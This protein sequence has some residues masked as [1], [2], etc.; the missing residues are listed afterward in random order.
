MKIGDMVICEAHPVACKIGAI[1]PL[2]NGEP[3]IYV[4]YNFLG[5][6]HFDW[7]HIWEIQQV[8]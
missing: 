4:E 3:N 6:I 5:N 1:L 2:S 7:L 8:V